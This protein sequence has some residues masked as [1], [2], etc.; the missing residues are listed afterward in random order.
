[1]SERTPIHVRV[2]RAAGAVAS[3]I[4]W[5]AINRPPLRRY[6][7]RVLRYFILC[8]VADADLARVEEAIDILTANDD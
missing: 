4:I 3:P 6:R 2:G 5:W 8:N 1:M 7:R